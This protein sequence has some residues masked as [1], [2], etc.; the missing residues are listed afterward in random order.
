MPDAK[1]ADHPQII[2]RGDAA[3][4]SRLSTRLGADAP[5]SITVVGSAVPLSGQLTAFLCSKETPGGTILK[6][7]DQAAAWRDAGHCVIS[8]F[9]SPLEQQCLE[10]LLRGKQPVLVAIARGVGPLRLATAQRKALG[11]GRLTIISPFPEK[12]KRTTADLARRRNRFVAA[13]ADEVVFAFVS[14]GGSLS[15]LAEEV[16]TWGVTPR[17]LHR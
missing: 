3:Y 11:D 15:R 7:F 16:A 9:H 14:P 2:S 12:E 1:R 6:A 4:P 5:L 13:L 10:I 17:H 8:G